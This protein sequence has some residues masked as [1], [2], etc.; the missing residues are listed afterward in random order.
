MLN[1]LVMLFKAQ[2]YKKYSKR[3]KELEPTAITTRFGLI[4]PN[5]MKCY[6]KDFIRLK[7]G[8]RF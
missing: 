7:Y 3:K 4:Y 5:N 6:M 1:S 8:S 2:P